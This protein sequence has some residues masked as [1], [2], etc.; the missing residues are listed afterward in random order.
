MSK[1]ILEKIEDLTKEQDEKLES[2][3]EKW[4]KIGLRAGVTTRFD[5]RAAEEAVAEIYA[6]EKLKAPEIIWARSPDEAVQMAFEMGDEKIKE[7]P[8]NAA[9]FGQHDANWLGFYDFFIHEVGLDEAKD[10]LPMMKLAQHCGWW[11][12]YE[13]I[14][15]L[16]EIP[17]DLH[18]DQNGNLHHETGPA[19][20]YA[21]GFS[22]YC[23]SGI[24]VPDWAIETSKDEIDTKKILA[25]ENTEQRMVLMRYLGLSKFLDSLG[26]EMI[27]EDGK[28]KLYYLNVE[29]RK[30]GP[31]LKLVCPS[32]GREFLEGVGDAEKHEFI[33][34]AIKTCK[35]AHLWRKMKASNGLMTKSETKQTFHS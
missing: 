28:D 1:K 9:G 11:W 12:P 14:C 29:G 22:V 4:L 15:I 33:D 17:I 5:R 23:L 20:E 32:S 8:M 3:Y 30:I 19:I 18:I 31:Y 6:A 7:G 35:D 16:S 10:V 24:S 25:L 2:Y 26:A 27:D 21:D 34:P 13:N